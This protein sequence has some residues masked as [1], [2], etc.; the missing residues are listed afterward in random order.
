M[1]YG[2]PAAGIRALQRGELD[3]LFPATGQQV[4]E[5]DLD[6]TLA[7]ERCEGRAILKRRSVGVPCLT[8]LDIGSASV[9]Y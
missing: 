3:I 5:G 2:D 6:P 8:L 7:R 1:P 9:T 4:G